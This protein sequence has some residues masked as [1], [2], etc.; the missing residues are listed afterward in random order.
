MAIY[1]GSFVDVGACVDEHRRHANHAGGDVGAVANARSA[2]HDAHAIFAGKFSDWIR[3]L[4]EKL[5]ARAGSR[6]LNNRSHA[7][8]EQGAALD[9]GIRLPL[10]VCM[11]LGSA[12]LTTIE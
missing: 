5:Q 2:W 4:V 8:A 1:H 9:P 3:V 10:A 12:N 11:A 7:E 6:H